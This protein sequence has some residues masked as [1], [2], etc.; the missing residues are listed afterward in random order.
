M[1]SKSLEKLERYVRQRL[2][3]CLIHKHPTVRKAYG[4]CYKWNSKFFACIGLTP[5]NGSSTTKCGEPTL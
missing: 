1:K 4:M 3:M 5:Q 2:R